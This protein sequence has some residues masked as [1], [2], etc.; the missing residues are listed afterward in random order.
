MLRYVQVSAKHCLFSGVA[1]ETTFEIGDP[2]GR[3][4]QELCWIVSGPFQAEVG[5]DLQS[6]IPPLLD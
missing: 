3:R 5:Q 6:T 1:A 4:S 2:S